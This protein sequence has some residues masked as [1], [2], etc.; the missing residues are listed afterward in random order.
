MQVVSLNQF[1]TKLKP[2]NIFVGKQVTIYNTIKA[3]KKKK[4]PYSP[5][6]VRN[7]YINRR[8]IERSTPSILVGLDYNCAG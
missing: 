2:E 1:S 6:R 7:Y 5:L 4:A 3:K 8:K